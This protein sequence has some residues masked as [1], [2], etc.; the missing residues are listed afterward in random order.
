MI[1]K[2]KIIFLLSFLLII[3]YNN[4]KADTKDSIDIKKKNICIIKY[5]PSDLVSL[6]GMLS[7][8][9]T[10]LSIEA[11]FPLFSKFYLGTKLSKIISLGDNTEVGD[12]G[13]SSKSTNGYQLDLNGKYFLLKLKNNKKP[14]TGFYASIA[15]T[16]MN[17]IT[18][19]FEHIDLNKYKVYRD[20][21]TYKLLFGY[22]TLS[23]HK[24]IIDQSVGFGISYSNSHSINK[25]DKRTDWAN[26]DD[27]HEK[28]IAI[29]YSL[30]IGF[31]LN[32]KTK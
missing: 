20:I 29:S 11:D 22:Q 14:Y 31:A 7:L 17:T 21:F 30:K 16:Y 23:K 27:V 8:G 1:L 25:I 26:F 19:R 13:I 10:K 18:V 4:T 32:K 2:I 12:V 9:Y 3:T 15:A 5:V 6:D 24:I 28:L